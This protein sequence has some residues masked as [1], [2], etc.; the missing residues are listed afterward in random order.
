MVRARRFHCCGPGSIP[1]PKTEVPPAE[2]C[3]KKKKKKDNKGNHS[4]RG[5]RTRKGIETDVTHIKEKLEAH[6]L[7][8]R[9]AGVAHLPSPY[10]DSV[11]ARVPWETWP[12]AEAGL[13]LQSRQTHHEACELPQLTSLPP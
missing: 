12:S 6:S 7:V 13:E 4:I 3:G 5:Q 8:K 10:G 2:W 1:G 9:G 11:V